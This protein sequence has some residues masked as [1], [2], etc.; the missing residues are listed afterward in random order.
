MSP[1]TNTMKIKD[2]LQPDSTYKVTYDGAG[3]ENPR[4]ILAYWSIRGL[5]AP[6]RMMLS[7]AEVDHWI[8]FY[9]VTETP[10]GKWHKDA[11]FKDKAWLKDEYNP[12]MNLPFLVD[13]ASDRVISQTNAIF[14]FLGRELNMVGSN[15]WK[16]TVCEELLCE[17]M[18]IRNK[19]V[20]FA[21]AASIP[22][23][24]QE[25]ED[26]IQKNGPVVNGYDKLELFLRRKSETEDNPSAF[27]VG[28]GLT[29]PDFHL[30]E[31]LDQFEGLCK[32]FEL[33]SL[34]DDT[35][36]H[37]SA[38]KTSIE[39]LPEIKP[40]LSSEYMKIP[41]NNCYARFGSVPDPCGKYQ[42][43]ME[44]PW[45]GKGALEVRR[46]RARTGGQKRR[47]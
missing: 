15:P 44:T 17:V 27:L 21:Y 47:L 43:G 26:L 18:D 30:W 40:Y 16:Q 14:T 2:R 9:D 38:F 36:P 8:V 6:L 32:N 35:R 45:K 12:L 24:K 29:A 5:G 10:D 22:D 13:C 41:Y 42:R 23:D 34:L 28:T 19:M 37:L 33:P 25:A 11:Y 39:R 46:K 1:L 4:Y 7:A 31:M 20:R 3:L